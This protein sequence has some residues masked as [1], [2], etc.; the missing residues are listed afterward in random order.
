MHGSQFCGLIMISKIFFGLVFFMSSLCALAS[1]PNGKDVNVRTMHVETLEAI[2]KDGQL[3]YMSSNGRYLFQGVVTDV[4]SRKKI[5]T[6]A[7][8]DYSET[9]IDLSAISLNIDKLNT[10]VMGKGKKTVVVYIDPLCQYCKKFLEAAQSKTDEYTFKIVVIPA[11][12]D[13][14]N[15]HSKSLFCAENKSDALPKLFSRSMVEMTQKPQCDLAQYDLTL[16]SASMFKI[17]SVPWFIAPDGRY[18]SFSPDGVW[19]WLSNKGAK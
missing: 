16:M 8:V 10:I 19:D 1:G 5:K 11:L 2:E 14:S 4:W 6:I 18:G 17:K 7:D 12:G 15:I 3:V 13:E 9:H